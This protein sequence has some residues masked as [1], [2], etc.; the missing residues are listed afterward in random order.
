MQM[1]ATVRLATH[2]PQLTLK[3]DNPNI[4]KDVELLESHILLGGV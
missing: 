2:P 3:S 4:V 1:K